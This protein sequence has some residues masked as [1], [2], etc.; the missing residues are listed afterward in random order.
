EGRDVVRV[1][2]PDRR[3]IDAYYEPNPDAPGKMA[4]RRGACLDEVAHFDAGLFGI[5]PRECEGLD[6]QQRLLLELA[7]EA[8]E[9]AGIAPDGLS[10]SRT[11]VFVGIANTDYQQL[12]LAN[13]HLDWLGAYYGSGTA[14]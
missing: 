4:S 1:V 14:P 13:G 10:R 9:D 5:T 11:G 6:P 3:V 2:P 12:A 8:F 7:W